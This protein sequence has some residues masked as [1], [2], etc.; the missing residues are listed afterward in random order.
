MLLHLRDPCV[1]H[2]AVMLTDHTT[3]GLDLMRRVRHDGI[4]AAEVCQESPISWTL[5]LRFCEKEAGRA[6]GSQGSGTALVPVLGIEGRRRHV[7]ECTPG[8]RLPP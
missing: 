2:I 5:S 6:E 8:A 1:K 3:E 7:S 4:E